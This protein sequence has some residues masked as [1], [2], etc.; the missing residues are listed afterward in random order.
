ML[1][2]L[3]SPPP[4]Q[5]IMPPNESF[6]WIIFT[7]QKWNFKILSYFSRT[8][9]RYKILNYAYNLRS[10]NFFAK[11]SLLGENFKTYKN[12]KSAHG[13]ILFWFWLIFRLW[14]LHDWNFKFKKSISL[15]GDFLQ[16]KFWWRQN[17]R[18]MVKFFRNSLV[19]HKLWS[20]A[21]IWKIR[22]GK[23]FKAK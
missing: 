2:P 10:W 16:P 4:R 13:W 18:K 15:I 12:L 9:G 6:K 3:P 7:S 8:C 21:E 20:N 19:D 23:Y 5:P 17:F 11:L 14:G 22:R 1:I